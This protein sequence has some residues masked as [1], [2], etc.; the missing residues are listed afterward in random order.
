MV[1]FCVL[2]QVLFSDMDAGNNHVSIDLPHMEEKD[3]LPMEAFAK[4]QEI[5]SDGEWLDPNSDVAVTVFNQITAANILQES[6]DSG[7]PRSPDSRSLLESALQKVKEKTKLMISENVAVSPDAFSP[8]WKEKD[9]D[10]CHR[11]IRK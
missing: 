7:S 4:V 9:T 11:S 2:V 6:L 1:T 8:V 5:F 10:S 3:G